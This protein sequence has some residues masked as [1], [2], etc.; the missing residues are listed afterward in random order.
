MTAARVCSLLFAAAFL[1]HMQAPQAVD[2][3]VQA[4]CWG[5][6]WTGECVQ[7]G[8]GDCTDA[9]DT[10]EA[11][12]ARCE[13]SAD[14]GAIV[15][16]ESMCDGRFRATHGGPTLQ[17][18]ADGVVFGVLVTHRVWMVDRA[19]LRPVPTPMPTPVPTPAPPLASSP[20]AAALESALRA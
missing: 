16:Q 11:A 12:R 20:S 13:E 17:S 6:R 9:F 18:C 15:Q 19:C 7:E 4:D 14:C 1:A 10:E 2:A 5:Q 3:K 8:Q